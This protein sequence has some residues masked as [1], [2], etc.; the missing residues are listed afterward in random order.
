MC[1]ESGRCVDDCL[2]AVIIEYG[3]D[4]CDDRFQEGKLLLF[5]SAR[6]D[7]AFGIEIKNGKRAPN[8]THRV[9]VHKLDLDAG[10]SRPLPCKNGQTM[11]CR[12]SQHPVET[13][14]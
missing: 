7:A 10:H 5:E 11:A 14:A 4:R 13:G 2:V 1:K 6:V 9:S 12:I 3:Y 8:N